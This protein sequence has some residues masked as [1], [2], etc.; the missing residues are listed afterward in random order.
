MVKVRNANPDD[1]AWLIEQI[2]AFEK[3]AGFKRQLLEDEGRAYETVWNLIAAHVVR[4]ACDDEQRLGFIAGYHTPHPFNTNI[5]VLSEI[6]WWVAPE[7]RGS[8]AGAALLNDFETIG[9]ATADWVVLS[10]EHKSPLREVQ[11]LKRGFRQVERSFLLE[12]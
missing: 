9:R 2:H 11:L 1:A 10:L 8:R 7:R 6:F 12:V 3:F 4:I 5:K